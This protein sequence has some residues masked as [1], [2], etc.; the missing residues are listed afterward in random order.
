MAAMNVSSMVSL[1]T[2]S[3][4]GSE[5]L[6][7]ISSSSWSGYGCSHGTSG[8]GRAPSCRDATRGR[9]SS[10]SRHAFVAIRYSHARNEERPSKLSRFRHARRN[11]SCTRSSESSNDPS[12]R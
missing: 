6:A 5:S 11:V 2:T 10:A 12:I 1:A 8:R 7:A 4:S 3:S 9:R